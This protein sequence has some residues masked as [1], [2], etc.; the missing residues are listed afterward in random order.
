MCVSGIEERG[1]CH[2]NPHSCAQLGHKLEA[3]FAHKRKQRVKEGEIRFVCHPAFPIS[4][5][6]GIVSSLCRGREEAGCPC[7]AHVA[8]GGAPKGAHVGAT[9]KLGGVRVSKHSLLPVCMQIANK[10]RVLAVDGRGRRT[11]RITCLYS[12]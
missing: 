10:G 5:Q 8:N 6:S 3:L 12:S 2:G 7:P 11:E 4:A 1:L 9:Q